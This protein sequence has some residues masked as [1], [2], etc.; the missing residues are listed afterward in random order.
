MGAGTILTLSPLD[1]KNIEA[2]KG[3][4]SGSKAGS[5][6]PGDGPR[7]I[8]HL[9]AQREAIRL[10]GKR[11]WVQEAADLGENLQGTYMQGYPDPGTQVQP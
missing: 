5:H 9:K 8:L 6:P 11:R 2:T 1:S 10:S 7:T 4:G 3:G